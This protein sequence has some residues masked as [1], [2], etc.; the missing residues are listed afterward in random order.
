MEQIV[1]SILNP[2]IDYQT[3][4]VVIIIYLAA[5]WLM[6]SWWVY[7]DAYKRFNHSVPKAFAL[8]L[9][10]FVLNFPALIFYLIIRPEDDFMHIDQHGVYGGVQIPVVNFTGE[11]G[12]V[13]L[14][15]NLSLNSAL[16]KNSDM[17]V[18][19]NWNTDRDDMQVVEIDSE[20]TSSA[21]LKQKLSGFRSKA[22]GSIKSVQNTI[23]KSVNASKEVSEG[24]KN[25]K[26]K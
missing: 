9:V 23:G 11:D 7:V 10:V 15:L 25:K 8:A 22:L 19:V 3:I 16:A 18:D 17:N 21:P 20:N 2:L 26:V 5:L 6:F 13:V 24:Q 12:N 1:S 14:S 4:F